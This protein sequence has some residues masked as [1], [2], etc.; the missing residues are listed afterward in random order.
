MY[1]I[2]YDLQGSYYTRLSAAI[3]LELQ[4]FVKL[5]GIIKE[6]LK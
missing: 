3:Y 2:V 4:D 5:G 1:F 6:M